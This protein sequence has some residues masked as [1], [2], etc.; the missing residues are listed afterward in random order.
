[1]TED[2]WEL[3]LVDQDLDLPGWRFLPPDLDAADQQQWVSESVADLAGTPGW[4]Q[5]VVTAEGARALLLEALSQR[6]ESESLAMMQVWPPLAGQTAMC[7]V[8][9]LSSEAMPSWT[10]LD[11]AV[12]H[13]TD[14]PHLG[15]GLHVITS[16]TGT[17]EGVEGVEVTGV[18]FIFDDGEITVMLS[19]DETVTALISIVLP[20]LVALMH[21]LRVVNSADGTVF[22]GI[23]PQGLLVESPWDFETTP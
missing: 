4:D 22:K 17:L 2:K 10:D 23:V 14:S 9:I 11:D 21:N 8:N 7:H 18:H 6:G 13:P 5:E 1:M 15:S 16:R 20:A 3:D 19:L 12:V